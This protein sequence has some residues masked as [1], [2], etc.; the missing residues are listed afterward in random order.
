MYALC[1]LWK[2]W[3]TVIIFRQTESSIDKFLVHAWGNYCVFFAATL[4]EAPMWQSFNIITCI[5][6]TLGALLNQYCFVKIAVLLKCSFM[7]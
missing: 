5:S 6:Y 4:A 2:E 7:L 3:H 1:T